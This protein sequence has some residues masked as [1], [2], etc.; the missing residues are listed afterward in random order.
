MWTPSSC[1]RDENAEREHPGREP[2]R[3]DWA[4]R[5]Y[6]AAHVLAMGG[7]TVIVVTFVAVPRVAALVTTGTPR[8]LPVTF[9]AL[10]V[11]PAPACGKILAPLRLSLADLAVFSEGCVHCRVSNPAV[12][13]G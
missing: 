3:G 4:C 5:A 2:I 12:L 6:R 8:V 10:A 1:I 7:E 9:Q 11:L 13:V